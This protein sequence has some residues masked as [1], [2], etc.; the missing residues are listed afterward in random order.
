M[1]TCPELSG[2]IPEFDKVSYTSFRPTK[3]PG[4][5]SIFKY[6]EFAILIFQKLES[7]EKKYQHVYS[8]QWR[9]ICAAVFQKAGIDKLQNFLKIVA[10]ITSIPASYAA[11]ERVFSFMESLWPVRRIAARY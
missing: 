8:L 7:K 10:F 2:T 9:L 6:I 3:R 1:T 5:F 4:I 11:V